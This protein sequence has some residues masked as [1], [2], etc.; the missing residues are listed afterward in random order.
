MVD[1]QSVKTHCE[2]LEQQLT[3]SSRSDLFAS[4]VPWCEM[5]LSVWQVCEFFLFL[6]SEH[7]SGQEGASRAEQVQ[8]PDGPTVLH[9]AGRHRP[10]SAAQTLRENR[11]WADLPFCLGFFLLVLLKGCFTSTETVALLGTGAQDVHLDFH[12]APELWC[13]YFLACLLYILPP[14][15]FDPPT[16]NFCIF[17]PWPLAQ[18]GGWVGGGILWSCFVWMSSLHWVFLFLWFIV[19]LD[20]F[21]L[22]LFMWITT[23]MQVDHHWF[24]GWS[25]LV[26]WL[27]TIGILVVYR[28]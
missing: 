15:L 8:H 3:Q 25:P 16:P 10:H 20:I 6:Q 23:G 7:S 26:Y 18:F 2:M 13:L 27:I 28:W 21:N 5:F 4:K 9:Q 22:R 12:T 14:D 1:T 19:N 11:R 24:V 17:S